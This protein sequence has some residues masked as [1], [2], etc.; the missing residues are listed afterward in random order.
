MIIYLNDERAYLYWVDH[1]RDG[2][3][4]D[5]RRKPGAGHLTLHRAT[6]LDVK[7]RNGRRSHYTTGQRLK[8]CSLDASEL[9]A[10]SNEQAGS[11]PADCPLCRPQEEPRPRPAEAN[12]AP[13]LSRLPREI[14][15][16]VLEVAALHLENP[17]PAYHLTVADAANCFSKTPAQ[18]SRPLLQLWEQGLVTLTGRV[19][20]GRWLNPG[21]IVYPTPRA[22]RTLPALAN[23]SEANVASELWKLTGA[24][25]QGEA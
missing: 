15:D 1:H 11:G 13:H 21:Q 12:S 4:L 23:E 22:L 16:F 17:Q 8:A 2:F 14:L 19:V 10:W 3:V 25:S 18:I 9:S 7:K 6:C 24:T 20:A 5:G